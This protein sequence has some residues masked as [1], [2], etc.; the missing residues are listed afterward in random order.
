[1]I[2]INQFLKLLVFTISVNVSFAVFAAEEE[3]APA[4]SASL[5]KKLT[6]TEAFIASGAYPQARELLATIL[7][8]V[9]ANSYEQAISLRSLASVYALENNYKK[10][11]KLIEQ[12][13][14][15]QQLPASQQQAAL[16][17]LGQLYMATEQYHQAIKPLES[18]LKQNRQ[19]KNSHVKVLLANAYTQLKHYRKALP[20]IEAAIKQTQQPK[21]SWIQLNLALYY[22]LKNYQSAARLLNKL[23]VR[24]PDKKQYWQQLSSAY[25]Q[26]RHY[27]KALSIQHL[28]YQKGLFK[29][30][31]HILQIVNLFLYTKQPYQAAQF[32]AYS[33][34]SKQLK[35]SAK[36]FELLA[37]SWT[38]AREYTQAITALKQASALDN[39]GQLYFR[40]GRIHVEQ[41]L[42]Q[43]AI[44]ALNKAINK[45]GLRNKGEAYILLGMSLYENQQL[46][47]A[48]K[49]FAKASKFKASKKSARQWLNYIKQV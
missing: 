44:T 42:W 12:C 5:Y 33:L 18:W 23:I 20:H 25:Q 13:L 15:M 26:L 3:K 11:A 38:D 46:A 41:E 31:A 45:G 48:R 21:E 17:N 40:L 34:K 28:A 14:A 37:N 1:M 16:L 49:A 32:L 29:D 35:N 10:A 39:K 47:A 6:K 27:S 24:Y 8:S 22:E 36:H 7:K 9:K 43:A 2:T 30:E 4:I 19:T